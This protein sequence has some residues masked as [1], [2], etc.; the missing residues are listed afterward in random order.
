LLA[1]P[2]SGPTAGGL[3]VFPP[4]SESIEAQTSALT[5]TFAVGYPRVDERVVSERLSSSPSMVELYP[6][7]LLGGALAVVRQVPGSGLLPLLPEPK[8]ELPGREL[9][10]EDVAIDRNR[11]REFADVCGLELDDQLPPTYPRVLAFP[12]ALDLM[13]D[14]SFPFPLLGV[15]HIADRVEHRRPVS[16]DARPTLRV[17]TESLRDHP[18]GRQ[19]DVV[20]DVELDGET[21]WKERS[22]YLRQERSG[23]GSGGSDPQPPEDPE[24]MWDVPDDVGRRYGTVSGDINPIHMHPLAARLFGFPGALAHGMWVKARCLGALAERLPGAFSAEAEFK[25]PLVLPAEVAFEVEQSAREVEFRVVDPDKGSPYLTGRA[26][27]LPD[28]R[29]E[30]S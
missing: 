20:A 8:D 13:T 4:H 10:L 28:G 2:L 5:E 23:G 30:T 27:P 6:K 25:K 11:V 16:I 19:F 12:L 1:S 18:R 26:E 29:G 24:A 22:T 15:L 21:V 9:V 7:A 17:R 3:S 14:L